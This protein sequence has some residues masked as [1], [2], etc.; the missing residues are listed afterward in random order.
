[1][2][3]VFDIDG[4]ICDKQREHDYDKSFAYHKRIKIINQLYDDGNEIVYYTA[5]GMGRNNNNAA[6]AINQFY[7]LTEKQLEEWGAKYHEYKLGKPH[8]DV[9]ICDKAFNTEAFFKK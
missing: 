1:M 8:Y 9:F 4:T 3:Y 5:R 7:S 2:K 6:L